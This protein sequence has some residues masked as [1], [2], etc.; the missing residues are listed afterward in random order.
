LFAM[1]TGCF[2]TSRPMARWKRLTGKR[3]KDEA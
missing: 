3:R 2:G 1:M